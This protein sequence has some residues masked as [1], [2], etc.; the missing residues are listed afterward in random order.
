MGFV[1]T[2]FVR[3]LSNIKYTR[4]QRGIFMVNEQIRTIT[5][6][7]VMSIEVKGCRYPDK[8]VAVLI[9]HIEESFKGDDYLSEVVESN[10][11]DFLSWIE[12]VREWF[13]FFILDSQKQGLKS[14]KVE[15]GIFGFSYNKENSYVLIDIVKESYSIFHE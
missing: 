8:A 10:R 5:S 15:K 11:K 1:L 4:M 2:F 7:D 12:E 9:N 14:S 13:R 6:I 3:I